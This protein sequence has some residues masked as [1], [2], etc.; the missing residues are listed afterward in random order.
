MRVPSWLQVPTVASVWL[1]RKVEILLLLLLEV[2]LPLLLEVLLP[3]P[4]KHERRRLRWHRPQARR[5]LPKK[6]VGPDAVHLLSQRH[7]VAVRGSQRKD[8]PPQCLAGRFQGPRGIVLHQIDPAESRE[9]RRLVGGNVP[10]FL[11]RQSFCKVSL[12]RFR[13][14]RQQ[15][16][17]PLVQAQGLVVAPSRK[18]EE[19]PRGVEVPH[20]VDRVG[21]ID[22]PVAQEGSLHREGLTVV[23]HGDVGAFFPFVAP[24]GKD[25]GAGRGGTPVPPVFVR[26]AG[27]LVVLSAVVAAVVPGIGGIVRGTA[28]EA[29]PLEDRPLQD[30]S[31]RTRRFVPQSLGGAYLPLGEDQLGR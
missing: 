1:P 29:L 14:T 4:R 10:G 30:P 6:S 7:H 22:V 8:H 17:V 13:G 2:L 11:P 27:A 20:P 5:P 23:A 16:P 21:N 12:L 19:A 24:G 15:H 28:R 26:V 31:G 18:A 9:D 3:R 25:L